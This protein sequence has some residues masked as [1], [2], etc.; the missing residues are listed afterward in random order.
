MKFNKR[1]RDRNRSGIKEDNGQIMSRAKLNANMKVFG[2]GL[3]ETGS[4]Q[5]VSMLPISWGP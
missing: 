4:A 3:S 1:I 5:C 2:I